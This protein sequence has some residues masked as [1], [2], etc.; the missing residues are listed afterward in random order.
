MEILE[1]IKKLQNER[2]W[3]VYKLSQESGLTQSTISNMFAR[4][5][6]PSV[7]TLEAICDA[8]GISLSQFFSKDE[9]HV[10]LSKDE[11]ALI[12]EYRSLNKAKQKAVSDLLNSLVEK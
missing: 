2:G 8:F 7:Q 5:T 9:Q 10:L 4:G 12:E 11:K 3:S 6:C 1:K